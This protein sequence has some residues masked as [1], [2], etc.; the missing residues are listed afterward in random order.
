MKKPKKKVPKNKQLRDELPP[1][2]DKFIRMNKSKIDMQGL[3]KKSAT[4]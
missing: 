1:E 2:E 4:Y 3:D